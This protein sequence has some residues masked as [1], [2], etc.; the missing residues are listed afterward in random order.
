MRAGREG[1]GEIRSR[2][3][4]KSVELQV[5]DSEGVTAVCVADGITATNSVSRIADDRV[6]DLRRVKRAVRVSQKKGGRE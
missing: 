5:A 4:R 6:C 3:S 2:M 1:R